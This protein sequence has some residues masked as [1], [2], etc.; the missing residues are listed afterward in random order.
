ME[1]HN[2]ARILVMLTSLLALL[3]LLAL[4]FLSKPFEHVVVVLEAILACYLLYWLNT[5]E[6]KRHFKETATD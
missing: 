5:A 4:P 1:E 3:N 2:W 6:V